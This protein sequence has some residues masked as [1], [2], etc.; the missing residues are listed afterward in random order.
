M[1]GELIMFVSVMVLDFGVEME[2]LFTSLLSCKA[3]Y[4]FSNAS[5]SNNSWCN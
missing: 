1:E 2:G 3:S 4:N 5:L